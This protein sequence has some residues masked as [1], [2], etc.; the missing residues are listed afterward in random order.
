[1]PDASLCYHSGIGVTEAPGA[2][3][4]PEPQ[5]SKGSV[6]TGVTAASPVRVEVHPGLQ[7]TAPLL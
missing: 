3:S 5:F 6:R 2:A 7:A 1:M 4:R